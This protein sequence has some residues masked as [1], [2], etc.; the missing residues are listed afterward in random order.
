MMNYLLRA[1]ACLALFCVAAQAQLAV[2]VS[3]PKVIGQ[4]AVVPL[5]MKNNFSDK[6]ESARAAVFLLDEQ[7]KMVGQATHWVI[8]G[9]QDRPGLAAGATNVFY[10]VVNNATHLPMT[11]LTTKVTFNRIVLEGSKLADVNKD[12]SVI[13]T[14]K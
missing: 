13:Q 3:P 9:N 5:A 10:F 2:A 11:N 7:G 1:L 12:V 6:I 4:K 14:A 8:G